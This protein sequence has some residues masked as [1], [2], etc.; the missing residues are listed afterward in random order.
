L[1]VIKLLRPALITR[2]RGLLLGGALFVMLIS[3]VGVR[4]L[5]AREHLL[6]A[7]SEVAQLQSAI[8]AGQTGDLAARLAQI[9]R[10]AGAARGLT[11][12]PVWSAL[13][14]VPYLG[15]TLEATGRVTAAVD[16]VANQVLP[17]LVQATD[18]IQPST[19]R[20]PDGALKLARLSAALPDLRA[21]SAALSSARDRLRSTPSSGVVSAITNARQA[22]SRSLDGLAGSLD[23][24][25]RAAR[26]APEM[27][28][29]DGARRYLVMFLT[30]AEARGTGGFAGSY[31]VVRFDH[32][33]LTTERSGSNEDFKDA[34][35][36]VV[37]L[38]LDFNSRYA[39]IESAQDYGNANFTPNF[40]WA[41]EIWAKLWERQ[42]GEYIDGV[43]AVDPIALG[44]LL[45]VTGP[46]TLSSGEVITAD[47]AARWS[48]SDSYRIYAK[49]QPLRKKLAAEL[50]E[51]TLSRLSS[52]HIDLTQ[53]LKVMGRAAGERRLLLWSARPAEQ[54][55]IA[56]TPAAGELPDAPGPFA[57]LVLLNGGGDKLDYYLE[58]SL[59]YRVTSCTPQ[60][61]SVRVSF[62][63][64]NLAPKSGL[65]AYVTVRSDHRIV[66]V[67]QSRVFADLF[68]AHGAVLKTWNLDGKRITARL[69]TERGHSVV[70]FDLELP[71]GQSRTVTA[72]ITEP[73]SQRSL[74][75]PV[76]PLARPLRV[77]S[78]GRC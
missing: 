72:S 74:V 3:W 63:L 50:S 14:R 2:R 39:Q 55:L 42:S 69:S 9:R 43:I 59:D 61:R 34:P 46:V 5:L 47:N 29:A 4:G 25:Y 35:S 36:P 57:D 78:S 37:D 16:Q 67:G 18:M 71:P 26:I 64:T 20:Q 45:A 31:A 11:S 44:Y 58:R 73:Q 15:S 6:K 52:S 27:L 66:P 13:S 51:L 62:T 65:P 70:E 48:M 21:S 24:A 8:T 76:Q 22:L 68:L 32:G 49:D 17:P 7:R 19:L 54:A 41:A 28:G 10:E 53:L 60:L 56:G 30:P 33:K 12:D 23:T 40:P 1:G 77:T 38:G 75:I